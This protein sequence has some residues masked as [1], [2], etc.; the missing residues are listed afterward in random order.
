MF[1]GE[2]YEIVK[3]RQN[4]F[5]REAELRG[6]AYEAKAN[7]PSLHKRFLLH[8]GDVLIFFGLRLKERYTQRDTTPID[9]AVHCVVIS[10]AK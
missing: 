9:H 2:V 8:I 4:E 5:L 10:A 7:R 3:A 6:L 1:F